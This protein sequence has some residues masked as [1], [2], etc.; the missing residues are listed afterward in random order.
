MVSGILERP[1]TLSRFE[2]SLVYPIVKAALD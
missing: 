1:T 2:V